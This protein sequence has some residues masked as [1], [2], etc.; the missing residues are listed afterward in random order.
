[1]G[2]RE[3]NMEAFQICMAVMGIVAIS[4]MLLVIICQRITIIE[5]SGQMVRI[6][7]KLVV[8]VGANNSEGVAR[9]LMG[10]SKQPPPAR[11]ESKIAP[12]KPKTGVTFTMGAN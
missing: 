1:M 11:P 9:G 12:E 5:F 6:N 7:D 2:G 3:D 4:S 10:M 8:L